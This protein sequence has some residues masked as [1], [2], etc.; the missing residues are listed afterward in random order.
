[1]TAPEGHEAPRG[2]AP[3]RRTEVPPSSGGVVDWL[4]LPGG[5]PGDPSHVTAR[6]DDDARGPA[7]WRRVGAFLFWGSIQALPVLPRTLTMRAGTFEPLLPVWGGF[8]AALA[9]AAAFAWRFALRRGGERAY[10]R[11]T[12]RLRAIPAG[13]ARRLPLVA[14]PLMA[15]VF[16]SFVLV[17]RFI[18]LPNDRD[19]PISAY[20]KLPG[21]AFTVLAVAAVVAPLLEEFFFRGWIQRRLEGRMAGVRAVLLTA[22]F[23]AAVHFQAFGFPAR[24]LFGVVAG[25]LAWTTRSIWPGVLMHGFYNASL[26]VG[27]ALGPDV[28]DRE[29]VR[30]AHRPEIFWPA[31]AVA[32]V[33]AALL[34]AALRSVQRAS[35][36]DT[37]AVRAT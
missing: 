28:S 6:N 20:L 9:I 27:G 33:A 10:R 29:L 14:L 35:G 17:P 26:L 25:H 2:D 3:D 12:F 5:V 13:V 19:D 31:A 37:G 4:V 24:L 21:G 30:W 1:M 36:A 32:V 16:A 34:V 22:L 18:P 7:W 23:F 15:M 11:E 8:L